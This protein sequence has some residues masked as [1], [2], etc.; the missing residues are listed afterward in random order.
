MKMITDVQIDLYGETQ[1]YMASAK[2][3]D[4]ATRY[5]RVQL[6]NNGTE[7]QIPDDVML[8]ANIKKPDGKFCY[9]ECAKQDNRVM[10]QLTNQALAAAGTAYCDIE[11]RDE[12]GELILSSAVFT[13][14]IEQSMRDERAIESSNEMTFLDRKVQKYID[15]MLE[16]KKM[17]ILTEEG[18]KLAEAARVVAEEAR[19]REEGIR[20]KN[21]EGRIAAEL[22]RGRQEGIR[23]SQEGERQE[24]TGKAIKGAKDATEDANEAA[25]ECR[26]ATQRAKDVLEDKEHLDATLEE[27]KGIKEEVS[28]I[29][30]DVV[31]AKGFVETHLADTDNPHN[32]TK[33][34]VGLGNVPNV[35]TNDQT[36]TF[37]Q[38]AARENIKSGEKLSLIFGKVMKWFS[39]LKAVAFSG[40]YNDLSDRP[41]IGNGK[42]TI[43]QGGE[44]KG[45]FTTNQS[46]DGTIDLSVSQGPIG[47]TG[48]Q[49]PKGDTGARGAT[50]PQGPKGDTGATGA[51]G[52]QGPK[53]DTGP[54]GLPGVNATTTAVATQSANGLMS[55]ADK[56]K[57]DGIAASASGART[58][59]AASNA[60]MDIYTSSSKAYIKNGWCFVYLEAQAKGNVTAWTTIGYI[61]GAASEIPFIVKT[62]RGGKFRFLASG[63]RTQIM[64]MS[65]ASGIDYGSAAFPCA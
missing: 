25:E 56:K 38:A 8:I 32:A 34:Q 59:T 20:D 3:G 22:E 39:D 2:Q 15:D 64:A 6:M 53:G 58:I 23:Q 52:P 5:I 57:L 28:Q 19:E 54:R 49:G 26:D 7:F 16:T 43:R 21:E 51:T 62:D 37:S 46:G 35:P 47:A 65:A 31:G 55:A 45:S 9:N 1:Y 60:C 29:R 12:N 50:G 27:A 36:P 44:V 10:V 11:M 48:P 33:E 13:I 18:I 17:V 40:S 14:E 24:E 61:E 30:S 4:K 41:G 42:I 63:N